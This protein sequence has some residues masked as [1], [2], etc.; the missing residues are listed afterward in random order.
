MDDIVEDVKYNT[1]N[2]VQT[3]QAPGQRI[4][5]QPIV[6]EYMNERE[7]HHVH[8]PVVRRVPVTRAVPVPTPVL[9]KV[10]IIR[11]IPVPINKKGGNK[12][13][14]VYNYSNID[15]RGALNGFWSSN[16][17]SESKSQEKEESNNS[18]YMV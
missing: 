18:G 12:A 15:L 17:S 16:S 11:R 13:T 1:T 5:T 14:K 9:N 3:V 7:I 2:K 8:N 10:P 4:I 6:Q